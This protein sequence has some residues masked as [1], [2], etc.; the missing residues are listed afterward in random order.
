MKNDLIFKL[1]KACSNKLI[2]QAFAKDKNVYIFY[3][4][5]KKV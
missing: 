5:A 4:T 1:R 3:L 2:E